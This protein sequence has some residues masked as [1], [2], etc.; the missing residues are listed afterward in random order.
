MATKSH[1]GVLAAARQA[2]RLMDLATG[3][4]QPATGP[5]ALLP[6]PW[7]RRIRAAT[8]AELAPLLPANPSVHP[9]AVPATEPP[10]QAPADTLAEIALRLGS[11]RHRTAEAYHMMLAPLRDRPVVLCELGDAADETARLWQTYF[12]QARIVCLAPGA[13]AGLPADFA[14]DIVVDDGSRPCAD[15]QAAFVDLFPRLKPGGFY[16]VENLH[17]SGTEDLVPGKAR[18]ADLFR[19]FA[20]RRRF[21]TGDAGADAAFSALAPQI[22]A[23]LMLLAR[24]LSRR[25]QVA[26]IHKR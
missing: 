7:D 4:A 20:K 23:V 11:P 8:R 3:E 6:F 22:S 13:L 1:T 25:D 12:S 26:V 14:P 9:S 18:A 2:A 21:A 17:G 15:V 10:A 24:N 19:S 16:I 5:G